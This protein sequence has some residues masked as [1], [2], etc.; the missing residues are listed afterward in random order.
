MSLLSSQ[1]SIS[2]QNKGLCSARL[3][4]LS[5]TTTG[6]AAMSLL[7]FCH[8]SVSVM[9]TR[10]F[11]SVPLTLAFQSS[12]QPACL[13]PS[14]LL[15]GDGF[16]DTLRPALEWGC[17]RSESDLHLCGCSLLSSTLSALRSPS[18]GDSWLHFWLIL[19]TAQSKRRRRQRPDVRT[20][21][22]QTHLTESLHEACCTR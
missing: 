16:A 6:L 17:V 14:H 15:P 3:S 21:P 19:T 8:L 1:L 9:S 12:I 10:I 7:V 11:P 4:Q 18:S 13:L 5:P 20:A 2:F 22:T